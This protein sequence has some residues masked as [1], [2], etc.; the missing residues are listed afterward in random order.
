ML[1]HYRG[2]GGCEC[3]CD[4]Q[5]YG[6]LV[7]CSERNDNEGTSVTNW[8]AH[9]ASEICQQHDIEPDKLIWVE[10]YPDRGHFNE[11]T[12]EWD[13]PEDF[14]L[15]LFKQKEKTEWH[16]GNMVKSSFSSPKWRPMDKEM[17]EGLIE[18]HTTKPETLQHWTAQLEALTGEIE[19][20]GNT[21]LPSSLFQ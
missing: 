7:I 3:Q 12:G 5:I 11:R 21:G 15:V 17:V 20:A 8:A 6:N 9:L 2:I 4:I 16:A 1:H 10:R 13:I 18:A 19:Q 14:S